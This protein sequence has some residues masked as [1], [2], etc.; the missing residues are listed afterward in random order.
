MH[1]HVHYYACSLQCYL[2]RD[3][4]TQYSA[5]YLRTY[6]ISHTSIITVIDNSSAIKAT[7]TVSVMFE[8]W[9]GIAKNKMVKCSLGLDLCR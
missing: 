4:S 3:F 8:V 2:E 6:A 5:I 7:F 9:H 1:V